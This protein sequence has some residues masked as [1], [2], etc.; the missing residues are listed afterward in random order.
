MACKD[1]DVNK[2][3]L[4]NKTLVKNPQDDLVFY[5][6]PMADTPSENANK[7]FL[8]TCLY[9]FCRSAQLVMI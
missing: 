1:Q 6:M 7:T 8:P 9:S 4:K 2:N 3:Y 5:K